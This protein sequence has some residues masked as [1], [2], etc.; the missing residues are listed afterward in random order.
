MS[1]VA[2]R[3][4]LLDFRLSEDKRTVFPAHL[5]GVRNVRCYF[6]ASH[7][8][9]SFVIKIWISEMEVSMLFAVIEFDR[10]RVMALLIN[11]PDKTG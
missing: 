7:T 5:S 4:S 3:K 11:R 8:Q 9:A 1:H 2:C 10:D 6:W